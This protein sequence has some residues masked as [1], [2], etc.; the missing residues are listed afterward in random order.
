MTLP[1]VLTP[2]QAADLLQVSPTTVVRKLRRG[3]LP[4]FRVGNRWRLHRS[5]LLAQ[6]GQSDLALARVEGDENA[7]LRT[8]EVAQLL[9]CSM[10]TAWRY[11][12][13]GAI[14]SW[15]RGEHWLTTAEDVEAFL[16]ERNNY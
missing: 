7:E 12:S 2:A 11:L 10:S 1:A 6:I 4:G 16:T 9:G 5:Q 15:R 8:A 3:E 13:S 14:R